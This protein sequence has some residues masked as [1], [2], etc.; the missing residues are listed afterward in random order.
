MR[1]PDA[2]LVAHGPRRIPAYARLNLDRSR[3]DFCSFDVTADAISLLEQ[4]RG[5]R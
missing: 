5:D 2:P 4:N 3:F 1:N